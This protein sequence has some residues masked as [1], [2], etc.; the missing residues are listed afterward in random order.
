MEW[1]CEVFAALMEQRAT[2]IDAERNLYGFQL[3]KS[4]AGE[5]GL[6]FDCFYKLSACLRASFIYINHS[7]K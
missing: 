4:P 1:L 3:K 2:S 7:R 6:S 5:A